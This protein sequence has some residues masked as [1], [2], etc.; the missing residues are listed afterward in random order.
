[1]LHGQS[2]TFLLYVPMLSMRAGE[3]RTWIKT[4]ANIKSNHGGNERQAHAIMHLIFG[5]VCW[6][7]DCDCLSVARVPAAWSTGLAQFESVSVHGLVVVLASLERGQVLSSKC[8][9]NFEREQQVLKI[10]AHAT[11]WSP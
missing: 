7:F 8:C 2:L 11:R 6:E 5:H 4:R 1:M 9:S 3:V 10:S